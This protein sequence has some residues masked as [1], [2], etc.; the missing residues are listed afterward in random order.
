MIWSED[1]GKRLKVI[2]S[3]PER[4]R[5][6]LIQ[7]AVSTSCVKGGWP[8]GMPT[9]VNPWLMMIGISPGDGPDDGRVDRTGEPP[10]AGTPNPGFGGEFARPPYSW[11]VAYWAKARKLAQRTIQAFNPDFSDADCLSL[12]GHL[13][14]GLRNQGTSDD[15]SVQVDVASWVAETVKVTLRPRLIV[16]FGLLGKIRGRN[17][18]KAWLGSTL[19][20]VVSSRCDEEFPFRVNSKS[21]RFRTWFIDAG[22]DWP[23]LFTLWP[24]HPSRS[25][26]G[27]RAGNQHFLRSIETYVAEIKRRLKI[28]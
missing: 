5:A 13:N 10:T 28:E 2:R 27:K 22:F 8:Y 14:L 19:D 25:P 17:L 12:A 1:P 11:D 16:G 3:L 9:S 26:F 6:E 20:Q 4:Q 18:K 21:Y 23:I 15:N 24:N 7:H